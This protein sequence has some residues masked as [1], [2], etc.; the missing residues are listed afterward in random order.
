M[1]SFQRLIRRFVA[2]YAASLMNP[3][4]GEQVR[5]QA[6][7]PDGSPDALRGPGHGAGGGGLAAVPFR[8]RRSRGAGSRSAP[9]GPSLSAPARDFWNPE[10]L[11]TKLGPYVRVDD[12]PSAPPF[13]NLWWASNE[14]ELGA[15]WHGYESTWLPASLLSAG[16]QEA[17]ASGA[18]RRL[19]ALDRRP[20]LQQGARRCA[21]GGHRRRAETPRVNP[22]VLDAFALVI[23]AGSG[24]PVYP[25]V[26]GHEPEPDEA[27]NDAQAIHRAMAEL[28]K[29]VPD[30][31]SYV[32]ESSYFE[33]NWQRAF[34]GTNYPAAPC[35]SRGSTTRPGSSSS[36][37]AWGARTGAR[38]G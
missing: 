2:F 28:R 20:A 9:T 19:E 5:L 29:L 35:A 18:L 14:E 22:A 33:P 12:R 17:L 16:R 10:F 13:K 30:P 32:L 25:G 1:R 4:W 3:H 8:G 27:R 31:G 24:P 26:A 34:W 11:T 21:A 23:I 7:Q 38:T 6:P 37:T 36:T 15:Y